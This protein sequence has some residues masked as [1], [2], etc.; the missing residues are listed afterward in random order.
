[1]TNDDRAV[2]TWAMDDYAEAGLRVL[3][4]AVCQLPTGAPVP[5]VR[6]EV[7]RVDCACS[8]RSP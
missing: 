7:E 1:M 5:A 8:A 2:V 6:E 3:A 4:V